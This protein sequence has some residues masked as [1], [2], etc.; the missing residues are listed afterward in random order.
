MP[1]TCSTHRSTSTTGDPAKRQ[2][3]SDVIAAKSANLLGESLKNG[4]DIRLTMPTESVI[5]TGRNL[6]VEAPSGISRRVVGDEPAGSS[7][8][9]L[10]MPDVEPLVTIETAT[11]AN[12]FWDEQANKAAEASTDRPK[13][14]AK[15]WADHRKEP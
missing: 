14:L 5:I 10:A 2:G 4:P 13:D 11:Y 3:S 12:P 9:T 1:K 8:E 6:K 15:H 7:R